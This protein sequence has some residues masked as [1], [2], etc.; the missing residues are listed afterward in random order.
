MDDPTYP[1]NTYPAEVHRLPSKRLWYGFAAAPS[2]WA[3]QGIVAVIVS[4][5]F[6]PADVPNWGLLGQTSV[7]VALG[8][9]TIALL[10]VAISGGWVAFRNWHAL[11]GRREFT[12]AEALSREAFMAMGGILISAVFTVALLWSGIPFLMLNECMRAR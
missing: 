1:S 5:Q 12:H 7:K 4:A 11:A 2:A 6:C 3:L 10:G 8:V 9:L